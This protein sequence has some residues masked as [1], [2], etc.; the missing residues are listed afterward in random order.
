MIALDDL[1]ARSHG[2][3]STAFPSIST[4]VYGYP[5]RL[6][7]QVAVDTVLS[8]LQQAAEPAVEVVFCCFSEG[9][10]HIYQSLLQDRRQS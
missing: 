4:G 6:A 8:C 3:G 9:D 5:M 7:A 10:L 1:L 2:L